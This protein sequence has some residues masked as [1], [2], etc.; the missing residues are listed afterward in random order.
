MAVISLLALVDAIAFRCGFWQK[1][2]Y[3]FFATAMILGFAGGV[4]SNDIIAGFSTNLFLNM[5]E[6]SPLFLYCTG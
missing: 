1:H 2:W 3:Y 6:C 5:T 4:S